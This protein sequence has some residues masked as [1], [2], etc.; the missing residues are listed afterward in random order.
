MAALTDIDRTRWSPDRDRL[1]A[2]ILRIIAEHVGQPCPTRRTIC[3]H[4]GM[5]R[6]RFWRYLADMQARGLIEIEVH[7]TDPR[8][9]RMRVLAWTDWTRREPDL[10]RDQSG[11]FTAPVVTA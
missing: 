11:Q 10:P 4:T 3:E 8:R 7:P 2:V 9:R 5:P 6:R 1:D